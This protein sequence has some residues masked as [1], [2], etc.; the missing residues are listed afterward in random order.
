MGWHCLGGRIRE[1][2]YHGRPLGRFIRLYRPQAGDCQRPVLYHD[3]LYLA[4]H[5]LVVDHGSRDTR[6]G[7]SNERKRGYYPDHGCGDCA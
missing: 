2:S 6:T 1:S 7:R 5:V 3:S 4:R